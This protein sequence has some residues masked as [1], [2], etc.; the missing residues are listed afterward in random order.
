MQLNALLSEG[1]KSAEFLKLAKYIAK[2]HANQVEVKAE[3]AKV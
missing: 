3:I 2:V 1:V